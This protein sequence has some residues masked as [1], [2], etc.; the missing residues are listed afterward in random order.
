MGHPTQNQESILPRPKAADTAI[1]LSIDDHCGIGDAFFH[2][3]WKHRRRLERL[4]SFRNWSGFRQLAND[5]LFTGNALSAAC[6]PD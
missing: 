6:G 1:V 5:L 2:E 3:F 4:T